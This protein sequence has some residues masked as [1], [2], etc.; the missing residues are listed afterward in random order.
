MLFGL[1]HQLS[2]QALT[3][4]VKVIRSLSPDGHTFGAS[5]YIKEVFR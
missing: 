3:D 1:R 4:L 5:A 2:G